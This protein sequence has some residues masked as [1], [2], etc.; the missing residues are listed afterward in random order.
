LQYHTD[1][2]KAVNLR[3]PPDENGT[4]KQTYENHDIEDL[5]EESIGKHI[6]IHG[7]VK[8]IRKL[9]SNFGFLYVLNEGSQLVCVLTAEG[10]SQ[11]HK[12]VENLKPL[13]PVRTYGQ[14]RYK[15]DGKSYQG[16]PFLDKIELAVDTVEVLNKGLQIQMPATSS[17]ASNT[18]WQTAHRHILIRTDKRLMDGLKLRAKVASLC[19]NFLESQKFIEVETPLLF[20]STPEGAREF[21]VPT[22]RAGLAYALPQSP[23]QYKQILMASGINRYYQIAK[24]FRDEDMRADRQPE[25]T[26]L[27]LEMSFASGREVTQVMEDLIRHV[28]LSVLSIDIGTIPVMT[29]HEAISRYGSDKP[30]LRFGYEV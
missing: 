20:K 7:Y 6:A 10:D 19:R 3:N 9:S 25:F 12:T 23:Q 27:D 26:Q 4:K 18:T 8:V 28:W 15:Q 5:K 30:D 22:R 17:A 16:S 21:L 29:Y 24:C 14:L 1:G 11:I 13:S 2:S